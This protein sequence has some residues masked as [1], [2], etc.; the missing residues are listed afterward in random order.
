MGMLVSCPSHLQGFNKDL[1]LP[2]TVQEDSP[3][4]PSP[5]GWRQLS[6]HPHLWSPESGPPGLISGLTLLASGEQTL[7]PPE[8]S[9]L[10]ITAWRE[11]GSTGVLSYGFLS[12][13]ANSDSA[14]DRQVM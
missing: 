10:R 8:P 12:K 11:A 14:R 1:V 3:A 13:F 9:S 4:A 5:L 2:V 6:K 7:S